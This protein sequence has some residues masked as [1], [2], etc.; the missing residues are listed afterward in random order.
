MAPPG[1][2]TRP[3]LDRVR[4]ALFNALVSLEAVE[5]ARVLDLYAGS[6]AL[7]IEA[8]SRGAARA[9][10]VDRDRGARRAV[11]QNLVATGLASRATVVAADAVA[12]L[13]AMAGTA[14]RAELVLLDPPYDTT[15][16]AWAE[17]LSLVAPVAP[18]GVVVVESER[19]VGLPAGWDALRRKRY[20][21]TLVSVL[22]PPPPTE[23]S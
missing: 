9:T 11:E 18:E 17:L 20:G 3:T 12:H 22:V 8:L 21:G 13:R 15:D 6:G 1:R 2:A 5:G 4:E 10:F 7:G 23:P 16:E 19:D 14:E